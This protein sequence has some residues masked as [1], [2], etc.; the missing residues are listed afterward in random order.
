MRARTT[1]ISSEEVGCWPRIWWGKGII[2]APICVA[3]AFLI[4]WGAS[5]EVVSRSEDLDGD[6]VD[7][8]VLENRFLR[9]EI[10]TGELPAEGAAGRSEEGRQ[11]VYGTRF[12]WAGWIRNVT[13]KPTDQRWF[14]NDD[15]HRWHGIPEEFEEAVRMRET[16][17]GVYEAL[18]V[19]IGVC[20]GT[21]ICHSSRLQLVRP[22]RWE[23]RDL[24]LRGG[25]RAIRFEQTL[26]SETGHAYR[27][28][29]T[30][31]LHADSSALV[32][33]RLLEN[34]GTERLNTTWFT[35]AFW[36][37]ANG[38]AYDSRSWCTIPVRQLGAGTNAIDTRR[39]PLSPARP[40]G[41]WGAIEAPSLG[42]D[43]YACG[44]EDT[45]DLLLTTVSEPLAFFRVWTYRTT[46]SC[47]PFLTL[48]LAPGQK[49]S[50]TVVRAS[51]TGM[52]GLRGG[53]GE[54]LVDW[55]TSP[56]GAAEES[57]LELALITTRPRQDLS[58]EA[59]FSS[60]GTKPC[61]LSF[62]VS[63]C[64]PADV[65]S[66][67]VPMPSTALGGDLRVVVRQLGKGARRE[68]LADVTRQYS[69]VTPRVSVDALHGEASVLVLCDQEESPQSGTLKTPVGAVYV[70][71]AMEESGWG[72]E[73]V[74]PSRVPEAGPTWG[75]HTTVVAA[76]LRRWPAWLVRW[77][78]EHVERGGGLVLAGP[79]TD[80]P[81]E[82]SPLLPIQKVLSGVSV[83]GWRPRDATREFIGASAHRYHLSVREP[84]SIL[85]GQPWYPAVPQDIA[86]LQTVEPK[87][88]ATVVLRYVSGADVLPR[89]GSPALVVGTHGRG[90]VAVFA[91]P[92]DWGSPP[93]WVVYSRVGEYHRRFISRLV[94]WSA[95]RL[96]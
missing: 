95:G 10:M 7:E 59:T 35:H 81:F 52:T 25:G 22:G 73:T 87:A 3:L 33:D 91:S 77:A 47:E 70:R 23:R 76:G 89:V 16:E 2:R 63:T 74:D 49:R 65:W 93:T 94:R 14:V 27:Y 50:W 83:T 86:T 28:V 12:V 11:G 46:Y 96:R 84:H 64:G 62:P 6:G 32:V 69:R 31:T 66:A 57:Q 8:V 20:V 85:A 1:R 29:K 75:R 71:D 61:V 37:Q 72:V 24:A 5:A 78:E 88:G 79:L 92:I 43:W 41:V 56:V 68:V 18:K 53:T 30:M 13:F 36:G 51:G 17:P 48:D 67:A 90:R 40:F 42:G 34:T 38:D 55:K 9:V 26:S 19:G 60:S 39:C 80:R 44:Q 21:G 54:A 15:A 4:A 58:V 82:F 45:G